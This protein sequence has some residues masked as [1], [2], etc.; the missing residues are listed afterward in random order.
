MQA[1]EEKYSHLDADEVGKVEKAISEKSE[2]FNRLVPVQF[3]IFQ[4]A[5]LDRKNVIFC[6]VNNFVALR[7]LLQ[8]VKVHGT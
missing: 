3:S 7:W 1:G 4:F 2:W 6:S 8:N 5:I